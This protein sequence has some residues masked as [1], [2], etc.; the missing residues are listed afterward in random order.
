M[1]RHWVWFAGPAAATTS[2]FIA[3]AA[4]SGDGGGEA[5]P[6]AVGTTTTAAARVTTTR[7][8]DTAQTR[9][10]AATTSANQATTR[11]RATTTKPVTTTERVTTT[12]PRTTTNRATTTRAAPPPPTTTSKAAPPPRKRRPKPL[13]AVPNLYGATPQQAFDLLKVTGFRGRAKRERSTQPDGL[14]FK[15]W[16]LAGK[17]RLKG[18]TVLFT[19]AS[20]PVRRPPPPPPAPQASELPPVVGLDYA[21]AAAR[22]ELRGMRADGYPV[23]SRSRKVGYVVSQTPGARTRAARGSRVK[24]TVSIGTGQL[25]AVEVPDT[26]GLTELR[27]HDICRAASFTCRTFVVSEGSPGTVVRQDP[28]AGSQHRALTQLKLYVGE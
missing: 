7:S 18:S 12:N 16:P 10:Q 17:P 20:Y 22:M 25:P 3:V 1:G 27:A 24:L 19:I 28:P 21:E 13:V 23:R 2:L 11:S 6:A 4:F 8:P 14:V 26:V 9:R 5:S 15:Q